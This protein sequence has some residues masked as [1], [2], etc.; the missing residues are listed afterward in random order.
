MKMTNS[1]LLMLGALLCTGAV[2]SD[3]TLAACAFSAGTSEQRTTFNMGTITVQ[4]DL[5]AGTILAERTSSRGADGA[6][7][8]CTGGTWRYDFDEMKF[9]TLSAYGNNVYDTNIEGVGIRMMT[10]SFGGEGKRPLPYWGTFTNPPTTGIWIGSIKTVQL[11][12][13][14]SNSVG[15]GAISTGTLARGYLTP[16]NRFYFFTMSL[17]GGTIVRAACTVTNTSISV[18]L[19]TKMTTDF[20]GVGSTTK[21]EAFNI[22][23]NCNANTR[24]KVT[25]DGTADPS[26]A[27][28]VLALSP[29][30]GEKVA[31]GVGVQVLYNKNPVTFGSLISIGTAGSGAYNIPLVGRYYQTAAKVTGGKANATAT[32]TMTYN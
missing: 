9:P 1:K 17:T 30:S 32:F 25:L 26:G 22:P 7:A 3:E 18:P 23:L 12:K 4:R 5:P 16:G 6:Y 24:V 28:G 10:T 27:K 11:V 2:F 19:G 15:A 20:T 31:T 14:S 8:N 13:T 29:S 21:D